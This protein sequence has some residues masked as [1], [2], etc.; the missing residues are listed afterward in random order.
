MYLEGGVI[1]SY[2]IV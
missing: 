1:K 2:H